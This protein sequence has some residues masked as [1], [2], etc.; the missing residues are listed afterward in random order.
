MGS[1][2]VE[3]PPS[4]RKCFTRKVIPVA[5]AGRGAPSFFF[6]ADAHH[7]SSVPLS[8]ITPIWRSVEMKRDMKQS[9]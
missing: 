9:P 7:S 4:F 5:H 2:M 3:E 6:F 1:K 8:G